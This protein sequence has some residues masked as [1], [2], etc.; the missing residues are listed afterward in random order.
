MITTIF[1]GLFGF[2]IFSVLVAID[3]LDEGRP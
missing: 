2:A 1:W 3:V